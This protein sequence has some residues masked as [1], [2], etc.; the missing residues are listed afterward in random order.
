MRPLLRTQVRRGCASRPRDTNLL[1]NRKDSNKMAETFHG[2]VPNFH[3]GL[4]VTEACAF[5]PVLTFK[6]VPV[7][8]VIFRSP[9]WVHPEP[10]RDAD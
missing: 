9:G 2:T 8:I 5:V 4:P 3:T 1:K 6:N 10:N 7:P